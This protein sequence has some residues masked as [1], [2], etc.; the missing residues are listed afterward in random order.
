MTRMRLFDE[1]SDR[2]GLVVFG[3][4]KMK[5]PF[6]QLANNVT[7]LEQLQPLRLRLVESLNLYVGRLQSAGAVPAEELCVDLK[8]YRR[9]L[10][11][12]SQSLPD[13]IFH[14]KSEKSERNKT[15]AELEDLS[16]TSINDA[17]EIHRKQLEATG[18]LNRIDLL[19]HQEIPEFAPLA[20][21]QRNAC[22]L[23]NAIQAAITD[24]TPLDSLEELRSELDPFD[25]LM[26]LIEKGDHLS[27][28]A[29]SQHVDEV[30]ASFG[31]P[32]ATAITRGKI[33]LRSPVDSPVE[34]L[35]FVQDQTTNDRSKSEVG[36]L[37]TVAEAKELASQPEDSE[38]RASGCNGRFDNETIMFTS[39]HTNGAFYSR[40]QLPVA[41]NEVTSGSLRHDSSG[42]FLITSRPSTS[43]PQI[44][45]DHPDDPFQPA[46]VPL[47]SGKNAEN[48]GR[49]D[50]KKCD[51]QPTF[52]VL[53]LLSENRLALAYHLMHAI[54]THHP[55]TRP[56]L[57]TWMIHALILGRHVCYAK[58]EIARQIEDDLKQFTP[59]LVTAGDADWNEA[60]GFLARAAALVPA[61]LASSPS[62]CTILRLFGIEP[63]LSHLYNY[64]SRLATYGLRLHGQAADLFT[65]D[66]DLARWANEVSTLHQ[67]I[68]K[69]FTDSVKKACPTSSASLMFL[70][71]HWTLT[72]GRASRSEESV[73]LWSK[74]QECFHL[75]SQLLKPVQ[76]AQEQERTWVKTEIDR[77]TQCVRLEPSADE[78]NQA[79]PVGTITFPLQEMLTMI[80]EG[81][82]FASH[83]LR[84]CAS[85]PTQGRTLVSRD[86]EVLRD[87][88]VERT[89]PVLTELSVFSS[90]NA[91]PQTKAAIACL[92]GTVEH[93]RAIFSPNSTL[94]LSEADPRQ[95][96][97]GELVKIPDLNLDE[98]GMPTVD[99]QTFEHQILKYVQAGDKRI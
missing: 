80:H 6:D 43:S 14:A 32:L 28:E 40:P 78:L 67:A 93:L 30:I 57:P 20:E 36:N 88:I 25:K 42:V 29:W 41:P 56:R 51:D 91:A 4:L 82:D 73:R 66:C 19:Q 81:M 79:L 69:W 77:L 13:G 18:V 1:W 63:G 27:D 31:R 38:C 55:G 22:R 23:R 39:G 61:L 3:N 17:L 59:Q 99:P 8:N 44:Q 71:A 83:W 76:H 58:G 35:T 54:E 62:A 70:H 95:V 37:S 97:Y 53:K 85:K 49:A 10:I 33:K 24:A 98:Q 64:C 7:E 46:T 65:P 84:L 12:L 75:V 2:V 86:A 48:S 94:A 11:E 89:E 45:V 47:T 9:R 50:E 74:W 5:K 15:R 72:G 60:T 68:K 96:V 16:G 87:E 90:A 92:K 34:I 21:C 26:S 52:T